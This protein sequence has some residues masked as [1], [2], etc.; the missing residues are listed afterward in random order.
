M[1]G[2]GSSR[3][4]RPL[5][6]KQVSNKQ[7]GPRALSGLLDVLTQGSRAGQGRAGQ[8]SAG[9]QAQKGPR[10][11]PPDPPKKAQ[12]TPTVVGLGSIFTA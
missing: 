7:P 11:A 3:P 8:G 2:C 6:E 10:R 4:V 12:T 1:S 5:D 9:Q